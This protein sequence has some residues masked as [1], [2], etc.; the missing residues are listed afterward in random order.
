M[1]TT[2]TGSEIISVPDGKRF[3]YD[4]TDSKSRKAAS[5]KAN[6]HGAELLRNIRE[7]LG[8]EPTHREILEGVQ[9]R[10][11][12]RTTVERL[13]QEARKVKSLRPGDE[14]DPSD[15]NPFRRADALAEPRDHSRELPSREERRAF[16]ERKHDEQ[17]AIQEARRR[18]SED[19]GRLAA[20]ERAARNLNEAKWD[21]SVPVSVYEDLKFQFSLAQLGDLNQFA[22]EAGAY[23]QWKID[24]VEMRQRELDGQIESLR[25]QREAISA[26]GGA[27]GQ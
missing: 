2:D 8:H 5:E 27:D 16:A 14:P 22:K 3:R 18:F 26:E 17:T 6:Q 25:Q 23:D 7:R 11:D 19:P 9:N 10:A 24:R 15:T 20:V 4:R 12:N 21:P 1:V 13:R